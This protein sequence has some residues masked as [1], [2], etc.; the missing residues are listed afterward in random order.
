MTPETLQTLIVLDFEATCD[1]GTSAWPFN[2]ALQEII[3]LPA[4]LVSVS[5]R[6]IGDRFDQV[7]RPVHQ[8]ELTPFCT[9]L[10]SL[11]QSDVDASPDIVTTMDRF[12]AWLA[13][14][15]L[16]PDNACVVTC[17]DW[18]LLRMWPKQVRLQPGLRTPPLFRRWCNIKRPFRDATGRKAPGMMGML[19]ALDLPHV[20][21]HHRGRDDVTNI[22][23]IA[24]RLLELGADLGPTFT[25]TNAAQ[26]RRRLMKKRAES[27]RR[28]AQAAAQLERLPPQ[29]PAE[30]AERIQVSE[31]ALRDEVEGWDRMA[32]VFAP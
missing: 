12:C 21:H 4:A 7:I 6:T 30:V 17:G 10:T 32:A 13:S 18:D 29:V 3:E 16:R 11:R 31:A 23:A 20:G 24:T 8:P 14:H 5:T 19:R 9:Q 1:D 15:D 27:E 25:P 26:E 2:P 22:A 28:R